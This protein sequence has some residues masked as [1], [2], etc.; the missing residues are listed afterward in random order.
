[1]ENNRVRHYSTSGSIFHHRIFRGNSNFLRSSSIPNHEKHWH[2]IFMMSLLT[3]HDDSDTQYVMLAKLDNARNVSN[4]LKAIHFKEVSKRCTFLDNFWDYSRENLVKIL[5]FILIV[6]V[7]GTSSCRKT[8]YV[9]TSID[10]HFLVIYFLRL[11]ED[12]YT[13]REFSGDQGDGWG[14]KM[15]TGQC[16]HSGRSFSSV[17][18]D[19]WTDYV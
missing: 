6:Y 2:V 4:I 8:G 18:C 9:I 3:Q 17:W 14:L 7:T 15:R 11:P 12:S 10:E 16:I 19:W 13:L 5:L 1:M